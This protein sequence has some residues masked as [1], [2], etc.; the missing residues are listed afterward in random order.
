LPVLAQLRFVLM[1][2]EVVEQRL[3]SYKGNDSRR[4]AALKTMFE[5]SGCRG[6]NLAEQAVKGL[7]QPNLICVLPGSGR[8]EFLIAAL[9]STSNTFFFSIAFSRLSVPLMRSEG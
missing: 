9:S 8:T 6:N 1:S 4:E 7:K 2:R 3:Q 5:S